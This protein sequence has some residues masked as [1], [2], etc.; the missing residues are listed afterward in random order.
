M[1]DGPFDL[2][3][4]ALARAIV[5]TI[6]EPL[7]VLDRDLRVVAASRSFYSAFQMTPEE[8]QGQMLYDLSG[9]DW[10]IAALR[11][12]LQRI[13]PASEVMEDFEVEQPFPRIGH[14]VMRLNARKVFDQGSGPMT[15][16]LAFEDITERIA[17]ERALKSLLEQKEMLLAEMS[18]RI[19]N[20]LQIIASILLMK[21]RSVQSDETRQHLEDAH[22]RVMSV[23]SVQQHLQATGRGEEVDVGSYL[24]KLCEALAASMIGDNRPISVKV[25]TGGGMATSSRAVSLGLI[26]TEL[27]INALKH[28]F[29]GDPK[30][31]H[32]IIGY[33]IDKGDWKLSVSDNGAGMPLQRPG[34][35]KPGL[36]ASLIKALAQQLDAQVEIA[37]GPTGTTV[38]VTHANFK[39]RL[40]Q[41]PL[42]SN[43]ACL[44]SRLPTA[45]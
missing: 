14:R 45:A 4:S 10:N 2:N 13:L 18:H 39:S 15:I 6:R 3:D 22:R 36:G 33:E 35:D 30:E 31:G 38:S 41:I 12:L 17:A 9:G 28:A 27:L 20:S 23:A 7:L 42:A 26:I 19:A 29:P 24:S 40:P 37:T 8:T 1:S 34:E 32:V 5:D 16:L 43:P 44:K 21:A 11:L 25:V